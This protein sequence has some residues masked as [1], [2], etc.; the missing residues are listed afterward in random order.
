MTGLFNPSQSAGHLVDHSSDQFW[1]TQHSI[2]EGVE[3]FFKLV[4][5]D[6]RPIYR[7]IRGHQGMN[8]LIQAGPLHLCL[9]TTYF[10][11]D[12]VIMVFKQIAHMAANLSF[13]MDVLSL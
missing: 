12:G 7:P 8:T 3:F 10:I 5:R 11:F 1:V 4:E 9:K 13:I 2:H 6:I